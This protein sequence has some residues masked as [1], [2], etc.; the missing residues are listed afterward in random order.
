MSEQ[1]PQAPRAV[2]DPSDDPA[3]TAV[4]PLIY[5][6]QLGAPGEFPFTRG[7]HAEMYTKGRFPTVR[8]YG[9]FGTAAELHHHLR[10]QLKLGVTGLSLA[11]DLP[12]QIG[13]DPDHPL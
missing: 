1:P 7:I 12:T 2:Y 9:G 6:Q 4:D 8:K 3:I 10:E 5:R 11:Y 13:L